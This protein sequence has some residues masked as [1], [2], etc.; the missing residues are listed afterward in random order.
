MPKGYVIFTEAITDQAGMEAYGAAAAPSIVESGAGVLAVDTQPQVLE[1]Q[2]HGDQTVIL[3]FESVDAA[4]AWYESVGY[5]E[6]KPLRH[7]AADTNA[8]I[9][10]GFG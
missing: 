2:W 10:S 4:R 1:G 9:I 5:G 8:V 3:E 6:A 7:A